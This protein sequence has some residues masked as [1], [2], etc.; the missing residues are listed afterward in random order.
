M[1]VVRRETNRRSPLLTWCGRSSLALAMTGGLF[2]STGCRFIPH[3]TSPEKVAR[4]RE[5]CHAGVDACQEG[6]VA[7]AEKLLLKAAK[8]CP[9]D[10]RIHIQLAELFWQAG[11]WDLAMRHMRKAT[12]LTPN[13]ARLQ[14]RYGQMLLD[15]GAIVAAEVQAKKAL[16]IDRNYP[17]GWHLQGALAQAK[18]DPDAAAAA[19]YRVLSI[20]PKNADAYRALVNVYEANNQP[21]R[22]LGTVQ[23]WT[24]LYPTDSIPP[25]IFIKEAI[26]LRKL[27]R[28]NEAQAKLEVALKQTGPTPEL[29][30]ELATLQLAQGNQAEA[31]RVLADSIHR[32]PER[33]EFEQLAKSVHVQQE[34][35]GLILR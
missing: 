33:K 6:D 28:V 35:S 14:V 1:E 8:T 23:A 29:N 16:T 7:E 3:P 15:S 27:S 2:I 17:P 13:D 31:E 21:E 25:E 22:A 32:W 11:K 12:E 18:N 10:E 26:A 30:Y 4:A 24:R 19:Y 5:L 9:N 34:Y 20:E